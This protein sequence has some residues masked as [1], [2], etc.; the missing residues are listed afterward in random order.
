MAH[1]T[2]LYDAC[3]LYPAPLRDLLMRLALTELFRAKWTDQ[4]HDEWIQ[5]LLT[6]RPDIKRA[7]LERT[8]QLMNSCVADS[9]VTG[10]EDLIPALTLPDPSDRHVFAAAIRGHADVIVTF[11]LS[12]FPSTRLEPYGIEAQHPDEFLCHLID[13]DI[14]AV[15]GAVKHQ[16]AALRSPPKSASELLNTL[17]NQSLPQSI[18]R[19]RQFIAL[20]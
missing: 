17:E 1:F 11:N 14:A 19:L 10:Y 4:I 9:L 18:A 15:C 13:L 20:L 2:A 12:D 16:R 8:R 3:V 7:Q 6:K 5:N